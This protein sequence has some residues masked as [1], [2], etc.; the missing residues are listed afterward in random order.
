MKSLP[1]RRIAMGLTDAQIRAT[2]KYQNKFD[3]IKL[4]VPKGERE[5]L[6]KHAQSRGESL[7]AFLYRAA[8]ETV[9]RDNTEEKEQ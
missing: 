2:K 6:Q 1:Q 4:R 8:T 3:D 9:A 7:N 5:M